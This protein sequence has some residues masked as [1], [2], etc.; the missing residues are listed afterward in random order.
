MSLFMKRLATLARRVTN[1]PVSVTVTTAL[2]ESIRS[3]VVFNPDGADVF[4][5][6]NL[7]KTEEDVLDAL[8]HELAHVTR[9]TNDH[10]D[11]FESEWNRILKLLTAAYFK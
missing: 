11:G 2:D 1:R 5:N 4:I 3:S 7:C 8:A 6:G 9:G 10:G